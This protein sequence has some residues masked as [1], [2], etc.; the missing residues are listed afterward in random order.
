MIFCTK[1]IVVVLVS[2]ICAA[3]LVELKTTV[4]SCNVREIVTTDVFLQ[5]F[6]DQC[7]HQIF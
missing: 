7:V 3:L 1:N 2:E 4:A 5:L 6:S